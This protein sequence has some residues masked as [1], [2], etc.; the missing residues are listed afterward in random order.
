MTTDSLSPTAETIYTLLKHEAPFSRQELLAETDRC[1]SAV[2][3]ALTT[4]EN[5]GYVDRTRKPDNL[6]QTIVDFEGC[7]DP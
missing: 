3:S 2:D 6:R 1:E 7:P 4:L 5:R